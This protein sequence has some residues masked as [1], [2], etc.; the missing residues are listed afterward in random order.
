MLQNLSP[1]ESFMLVETKQNLVSQYSVQLT[2]SL[3]QKGFI[4]I[5]KQLFVLRGH[6]LVNTPTAR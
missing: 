6:N 4:E 1:L 5:L 2:N 3:S